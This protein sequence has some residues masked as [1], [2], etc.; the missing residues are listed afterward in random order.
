MIEKVFFTNSSAETLL[1]GNELAKFLV[2]GSVVALMGDL[3]VGKTTLIKGIA[4]AFGMASSKVTSPTFTY[5]HI[6][7]GTKDLYHF[8]LYRIKDEKQFFDMGFYEHLEGEGICL[9]EWPEKILAHLPSSTILIT[10]SHES[11]DRR[12]IRLSSLKSEKTE[13]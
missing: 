2:G 11:E 7:N 3:G 1:L 6:Y 5:L 9:L 8:D 12:K 13:I 4:E 10:L